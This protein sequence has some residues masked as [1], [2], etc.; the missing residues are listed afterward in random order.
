MSAQLEPILVYHQQS[1]HAFQ[2]FARGP[3]RLD[4][5]TQPDPFRRYQGAPVLLLDLF[6]S[7]DGPPYAQALQ[8][9]RIPPAALDRAGVSRLFLDSLALSAWKQASGARWSLRVNP[10]S[11]NLHPTEGYLISGP[12]S[13]LSELPLVAHYAPREHSLEQRATFPLE[14]WQALTAALPPQSLLVG[15]SSIHWRETWK[16]GERAYRYCQHDVGHALAAI[17]VAAAGLGWRTRLLD[18]LGTEEVGRLLGLSGQQGVEREH[19]DCLLAVY[20]YD[21]ECTAR[22]LP[23]AAMASFAELAWEGQANR[24][25]PGHVPWPAV[26]RVDRAAEKPPTDGAYAGLA[27]AAAQPELPVP[28]ADPSLRRILHQRRSAVNMDGLTHLSQE[29]FYAIL[30][31]TLPGPGRIPFDVL[32]WDPRVHLVLFVHRVEGLP[33]GLYLLLRD[34]AQGER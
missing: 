14:I 6:D 22:S 34:P 15:L 18:D 23:G 1:K 19:P 31:R 29:S 20:P 25:S 2:A 32:P 21:Q 17:R 13:G 7:A 9:G 4:W 12:L 3:E 10:S 33:A 11:G 5:S 26:E 24:L 28:N 16:Y 30:A 8:P 27:P